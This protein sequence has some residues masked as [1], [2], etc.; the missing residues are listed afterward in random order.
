MK[1]QVLTIAI[2]ALSM[3]IGIGQSKYFAK[4]IKAALYIHDT[5]SVVLSEVEAL[6]AFQGLITKYPKEWLPCYWTAYLCTQIARLEGRSEDFPKDLNAK[7]L[8]S[9]AKKYHDQA[10]AI[11]GEMTNIE[12]SDF[13]MLE[14]FIYGFYEMLGVVDDEEAGNYKTLK[15]SKYQEAISYNPRNPLMYVLKGISLTQQGDYQD[16][17]AG[18]ALLDY[19][20]EIFNKAE[21]RGLT[22]Y[23][24]KDFIKFWRGRAEG[25]LKGI[26]SAKMEDKG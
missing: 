15:Q 4:D 9:D 19:A 8:L 14:G 17:M 10:V 2:L 22:T 5:A 21:N 16:V 3:S 1:K 6:H 7:Q 11:K 13:L 20:E 23:W 25:K 12:R 24:N 18:I 26:L